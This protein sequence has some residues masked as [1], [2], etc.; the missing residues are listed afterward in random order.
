MKHVYF[1]SKGQTDGDRDMRSLLGGKGANLA[2]MS[3][4][5]VPVPP[6]FTVTT[7]V[8]RHHLLTHHLPDGV[9]DQVSEAIRR[10]ERLTEKQFGG[11]DDPL[12]V[13]VRSGGAV[14]MPGMMDTVLNLGLNDQ[15]VEALA[16]ISGNECFAYDSYRRFL[17]MYSDVVLEVGH[18]SFEA[19]LADVKDQAGVATDNELDADALRNVVRRYKELIETES[20]APFPEKPEDQL[21]GAIEAVFRSWR[22]PRAQAY[23]KTYRIPHDLG[24]AVNVQTMVYGNRGTDSATG[25]A[26]TRNAATGEPKL[27]GE[28][29]INAQGEDVVA[30]IRDPL[31]IDQ[32]QEVMPEAYA[33][34]LETARRLETH[35]REME[36]LEFTIEKGTLYL[37][38]TRSGKRTARAAVRIAVDMANEGLISR[39]EAVLR[40]E[41][42]RLE[43]VLHSMVDPSVDFKPLAVGNP[44]SPGASSGRIVFTAKEAVEEALSGDPVILV[45]TE[46]SPDDFEGMVAAVAIVTSRGG[47]SS[48]AAVVARG[49]G[50]CCVVGT[51]DLEIDEEAGEVRADGKVVRRGDWITVDG[52]SGEVIEG[53]IPTVKP[54]PGEDFHTLMDWADEFRHLRVRTNADNPADAA[55]AREFGAEGIGLCRTEHMFFGEERIDAVREMILASDKAGRATALAKLLPMQR[56]DFAGIFRAM[57]GLPVTIRLLDPPLHEFLPSEADEVRRLAAGLG[58]SADQIEAA[59]ARLHEANPM[60]G[61]RGCRLGYSHPEI[62]AMQARAIIE[63]AL[64]VAGE[65]VEVLPEIMVPLVGHEDE[66]ENQRAIVDATAREIFAEQDRKIDYLVGTMIELPRACLTAGDIAARAEFFSFGTND[67]TQ[68]T[69]GLSRDDAGNFLPLYV[70][71]GVYE[72]DPF[73]SI[74]TAG[75]GRLMRLAVEEGRA[76]RPDLKVGICGEHGGDPSSVTFCHSL[77][78][79]YVS[80]SPFRVPVARLAAAHAALEETASAGAEGA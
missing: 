2:E 52:A 39:E 71:A 45:R 7:E 24:T 20:D 22:T 68:T 54:E 1:F 6:G 56:S 28:F 50:K 66:L 44:A 12:L 57:D 31:A 64:E 79:Q 48:H 59:V 25:V 51:K 49:M 72:R 38:Q 69:L 23:R 41:P 15:T 3:R 13:S 4:L 35:Y 55:T 26:F 17:Q 34:L 30:G 47:K 21:W 19:I 42:D 11:T 43:Q 46:T 8:C 78:M 70:E 62:T 67:L 29:L 32:M 14:S 37:L 36:D 18:R 61:H 73:Q 80:C 16:R 76:T 40:V 58:R 33:E 60:L 10:L 5:G 63:A 53:Q 65:G 77:G 74:D 9:D 75:V 27:F